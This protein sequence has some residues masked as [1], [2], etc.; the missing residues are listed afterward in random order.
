MQEKQVAGVFLEIFVVVTILSVLG[1]VAL[2]H[3]GQMI[4]SSKNASQGTEL[5]NIQ[6][7]VVEM[8]ADSIKGYLVP[9]GP[10][11]DMSQ[12]R[13]IDSPPLVLKDYLLRQDRDSLELGCS[14]LFSSDGS[15]RQVL[16]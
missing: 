6:T 11:A 2:P 5:Q 10:T 16:P 3:V 7:A 12:V 14:Y 8:L 15:V 1:A 4:D 13:T 9:V